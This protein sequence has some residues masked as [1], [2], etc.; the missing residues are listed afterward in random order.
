[1]KVDLTPLIHALMFLTGMSKE[2]ERVLNGV[3]VVC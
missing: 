1:M 2:R 3:V